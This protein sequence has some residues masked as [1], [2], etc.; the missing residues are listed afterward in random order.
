M[1]KLHWVFKLIILFHFLFYP[2][3]VLC[4]FPEIFPAKLE[5]MI[6]MYGF[7][8]RDISLN[9]TC[10]MHRCNCRDFYFLFW[11]WF[12]A[13]SLT[14]TFVGQNCPTNIPIVIEIYVLSVLKIGRHVHYPQWEIDTQFQ[15]K[16]PRLSSISDN[17]NVRSGQI[18]WENNVK[19]NNTT[20]YT[21]PN[22]KS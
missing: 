16:H 4:V 12:C 19:V 9:I 8:I 17:S 13:A 15:E 3:N 2:F 22:C 5:M 6:K 1:T 21:P 11:V 7:N 14:I 10:Q 20:P 18:Y